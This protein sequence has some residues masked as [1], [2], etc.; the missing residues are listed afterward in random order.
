MNVEFDWSM[1]EKVGIAGICLALIYFGFQA[2]KL[3]LTQWQNST[4]AVN[5]N[6]QAFVDL[7][8]FF[9]KANE[10]E[11]AFQKEIMKEL[12]DGVD[13]AKDTNERVKDI[14]RKL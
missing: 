14:Q 9:K 10:R 7:S 6:T 1:L 4:D 11:E 8:N 13:V 2:F 5:K 12:R 3:V